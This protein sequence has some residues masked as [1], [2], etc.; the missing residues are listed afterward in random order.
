[1]VVREGLRRVV[2]ILITVSW[3]VASASAQTTA[4]SQQ[5]NKPR[6][7]SRVEAPQVLEGRAVAP[8]VVTIVHRLNRLKM[9]RLLLRSEERVQAIAGLDDAFKLMDDV[10]TNVIAGLALDDGQTVVTWLPEAEIELGLPTIPFAAPRAPLP[11]GAW[12]ASPRASTTAKSQLTGMNDN[13]SNPPDLTVIGPDG[14]QLA[15][16]YVGLDGVTGLSI[17]KLSDRNSSTTSITKDD[18]TFAG[19][20]V[21]LFGPE[22]VA[23]T[24]FPATSNSNLY[25]R[26]GETPGTISI[27]SRAPSGAVSK[28]KARLARLSPANI[29]GVAINDAG[30]TVG[31]VD[32]IDGAEASILPTALIRLAAKRVLTQQSSVPKPWLGVTG[33]PVA[34]LDMDQFVNRGWQVDRA[35]TL[36][37]DHRGILLTWIAPGSP[38]AFA[39]LRAGDVILKVNDEEIQTADDFSWWL[40]QAGPSSS[41]RFTVA[42]PDRTTPEAINVRLSESLDPT[43]AVNIL[44]HRSLL[45]KG[46]S[47]LDHGIETI[48]LQPAVASRLG[49]N[50]GLLI[51]YVQPATPAAQAGLRAGDVIESIDGRRISSST[52]P[53]LLSNSPAATY[54]FD[55]VRNKQKMVLVVNSEKM[56]NEK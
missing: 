46:S 1:M 21:R 10:H 37:E 54:T 47:L 23:Q 42:R 44:K 45:A 7:P 19:Q 51:I 6:T 15:A 30:E 5:P 29:G 8:Q 35:T 36:A 18:G 11:P 3:S 20:R 56:T 28:F 41:V 12:P 53:Q 49:A 27:V 33:E 22:P 16:R 2:L 55:I 43:L 26:I 4:S 38:A 34:T 24:G 50:S 17:L 14:K 9:F 32:G 25:V 48:A 31:I 13:L 40:Q 52:R 39:A